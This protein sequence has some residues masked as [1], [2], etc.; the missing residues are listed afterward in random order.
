MS[1]PFAT[2]RFPTA[3]GDVVVSPLEHASVLLGWDGKAIYV[4]P[5]SSAISDERL[6]QADVVFVTEAR[7][8]HLDAV[9]VARLT[10]PGTLVVGP[11]EVAKAIHVDVVLRN[12]DTSRVLGAVVT[13]VPMYNVVRGPAPGLRYHDKGRGNG[14]VFDFDGVRL[15]VSGDSEC[16]PE[17]RALRGIDVA[18]LSV[19]APKTMTS[20]EAAQCVEAFRPKVVF[21]YHD[22]RVDLRDL[23]SALAGT[24][25]EVRQRD[26][27]PRAGRQ[28]DLAFR[29]CAEGRWGL[30]RDYLDLATTLDP[31]GEADPRVARARDQIRAW[32]SPFPPWW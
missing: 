10:R 11:P 31:E 12:G 18:F 16:T 19:G 21:P 26:F 28:R 25:V 27:Y 24:D 5:T 14:Y 6:P 3:Q 7:F 8:D 20:A 32:Q 1:S 29:A 2:D 17:M 22:R 15:Y 4:D 30:C 23:T 9:A 13:A